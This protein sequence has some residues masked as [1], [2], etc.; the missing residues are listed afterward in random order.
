M[1]RILA[2]SR[3]KWE[4][5][6]MRCANALCYDM[7]D[8]VFSA[9]KVLAFKKLSATIQENKHMFGFRSKHISAGGKRKPENL[10]EIPF[11]F[12]LG[13]GARLIDRNCREKWDIKAEVVELDGTCFF[14]LQGKDGLSDC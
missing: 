12:V 1:G 5:R 14:I 3:D 6:Y 2:N 4:M 7:V 9:E 11:L 8:F 13:A 10:A